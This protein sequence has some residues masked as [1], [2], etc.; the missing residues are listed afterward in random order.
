[1][2]TTTQLEYGLT[3]SYGSTAAVALSP[4]NGTTAQTVRAT[5]SGLQ[6]GKTYHYR[7]TASNSAG[8]AI[9]GADMTFVTPL[10][11]I[12]PGEL[13]APKIGIMGGNVNFTVQPSVA[14][15]GYQ[16]QYSDTMAAGTWQDLGVQRAGDGAD[17]VITIPYDPAVARRFYRMVLAEVALLPEGFALIPAGN[18]SMGNALSAW[19]GNFLASSPTGTATTRRASSSTSASAS[20]VSLNQVAWS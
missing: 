19:G 4:N 5:V 3:T 12:S 18:F 13:V 16:L 2:A 6:A 7:L 9:S 1:M 11:P 20:P 14:G 15:R 10:P 8:N 17:L